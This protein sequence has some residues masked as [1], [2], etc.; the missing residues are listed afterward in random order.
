MVIMDILVGRRLTVDGVAKE[1][2]QEQYH[3]F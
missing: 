3:F 2:F 1:E